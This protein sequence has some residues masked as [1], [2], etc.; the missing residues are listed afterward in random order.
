MKKDQA[1]AFAA[2]LCRVIDY[3]VA[4]K[5]ASANLD[6]ESNMSFQHEC[7]RVEE[8]LADALEAI[9]DES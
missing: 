2:V 5:E 6:A 4:A 3:F 7:E 9:P 1:A 8:S